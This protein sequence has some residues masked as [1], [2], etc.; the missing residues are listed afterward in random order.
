MERQINV[1]YLKSKNYMTTIFLYR[2]TPYYSIMNNVKDIV[3]RED[4]YAEV[5][6]DGVH[7]CYLDHLGNVLTEQDLKAMYFKKY[8]L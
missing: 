6:T 3:N 7:E 1:H 4:I 8:I 5:I 2:D